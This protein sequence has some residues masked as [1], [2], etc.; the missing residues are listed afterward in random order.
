MPAPP[1]HHLKK[2]RGHMPTMELYS[3]LP[4]DPQA[5]QRAEEAQCPARPG[6][7]GPRGETACHLLPPQAYLGPTELSNLLN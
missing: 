2:G 4:R 3:T 5:L 6:E 7:Q 1:T